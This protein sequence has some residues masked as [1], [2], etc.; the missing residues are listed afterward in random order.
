MSK[1]SQKERSYY[2]LGKQDCLKYSEWYRSS[3][4]FRLHKLNNYYKFYY[5]G[6]ME[7]R[8]LINKLPRYKSPIFEY[9]RN[10]ILANKKKGFN[11]FLMIIIFILTI[12]IWVVTFQENLWKKNYLVI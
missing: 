4:W 8:K 2:E 10:N 6:Y 9:I 7:G 5:K 1:N 12:F 3:T 11:Y